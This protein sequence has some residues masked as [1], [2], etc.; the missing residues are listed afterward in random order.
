LHKTG[1]WR[2]NF[3]HND[4]IALFC[5]VA[6]LLAIW[7]LPASA[8]EIVINVPIN[9]PAGPLYLTGSG[10][11]L[12]NWKPD[13]I[14]LTSIGPRTFHAILPSSEGARSFDYKVTRG[15]WGTEASDPAGKP[16][17]NLT[18]DVQKPRIVYSVIN[19]VD[20]IPLGVTGNLEKL[21]QI[22]SPELDNFRDVVVWLPP[23]YNEDSEKRYP[24]MYVQDGQNVFDPSTANY[25]VDWGIDET[26]TALIADHSVPETIV[27]GI[28]STPSRNREYDYES[29]GKKYGD[30]LVDEL[31]PMIDSK[32]RTLSDRDHSW[33]MGS[34]MGAIISVALVWKY[35]NVFSAAAAVSLPPF[36][37]NG[38]LNK[39][40]SSSPLPELPI[41]IYMDHGDYGADAQFG[42]SA[43]NFFEDLLKLGMPPQKLKYEVFPF[44]DHTEVDW[45]RRVD[46][47]L[48]WMLNPQTGP[49]LPL[50]RPEA[51]TL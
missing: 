18:A 40:I 39:T 34:S 4:R 43:Q 19:W 38:A 27:V 14:P 15:R 50:H 17:A 21:K 22:Y 44:A 16:T 11:A 23:H 48:R 9:T 31:K 8:L 37:M 12:C 3:N 26:M 35:P 7:S 41:R 6:L 13:C 45:A 29:E 1:R 46:L 49:L 32:Y 47:V 5:R 25:G 2:A 33:L 28:F 30:F 51:K 10:Y 24:V 20:Q 36:V 42:P